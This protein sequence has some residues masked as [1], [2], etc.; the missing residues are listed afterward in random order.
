MKLLLDITDCDIRNRILM[1]TGNGENV[2]I[3]C[4]NLGTR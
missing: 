1:E 2:L 3:M 4:G